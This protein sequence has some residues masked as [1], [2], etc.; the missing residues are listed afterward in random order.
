M[1]EFKTVQKKNTIKKC[2]YCS[3]NHISRKCKLEIMM[4]PILKKKIGIFMEH[5]IAEKIQCPE[6]KQKSLQVLG[7]ERPSLDIICQNCDNIFEV[8]SKCLS[9][10]DIPEDISL[11]HGTYIDFIERIND[12]LNLI[13]VIYG[14]DR[15]KKTAHIRDIIYANNGVLRN[16]S[17]I[18]ITRQT[19]SNL[20]NILIPNRFK[21]NKLELTNADYSFSFHDEIES[22][23]NTQLLA[24]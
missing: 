3:G 10:I 16:S 4:A 8:K 23:K 17:L 18:D 13:V 14:V 15:V 19:S 5:Y 20:S 22:Y 21:L 7:D 2:Y 11:L 24:F 1:A 6:C 12:G 9:A